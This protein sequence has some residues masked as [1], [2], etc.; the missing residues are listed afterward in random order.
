MKNTEKG[1]F[2]NAWVLNFIGQ[3]NGEEIPAPSEILNVSILIT[4][5]F[6]QPSKDYFIN[7][8]R[9]VLGRELRANK[10]KTSGSNPRL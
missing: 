10:Y 2:V 7:F 4:S 6:L 8:E 3:A 9:L 1:Q 5:P